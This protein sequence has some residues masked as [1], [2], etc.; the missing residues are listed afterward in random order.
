MTERTRIHLDRCLTCRSCETTCPSGVHY[1]RLIDFG[2]ALLEEQLP[3]PAVA[4]LIRWALRKILP[5]KGRF[6]LL[7]WAG[8]LVRPVMPGALK[9]TIP[10]K[11]RPLPWP[12]ASHPRIMLALEGCAQPSATPNTHIAAARVLDRLGVTLVTAPSAG[13][14]GA[15]SYHLGAYDEGTAAFKRNIDAWWP[16]IE[17]GAEAIVI[18]ASGCGSVVKEYGELLKDDAVY[19]DK[20]VRVS[21]LAKDLSE[22]MA[23]EDLSQLQLSSANKEKMAFHCP[24][25][26]QHGQ[27]LS[28]VV[29]DILQRLGFDLAQTRDKHHCCAPPVPT[30]F[31][32]RS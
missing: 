11:Q 16:A 14:C 7:L 1:G 29:E 32:S 10:P 19:A 4:R 12:A 30:P 24:C 6:G 18:S 25:S 9:K 28:G 2:R 22:V 20:A 31:C 23:A 15:V 26:L 3:R 21:A 13:C 27:Q 17:Q 5:Y 8:Q